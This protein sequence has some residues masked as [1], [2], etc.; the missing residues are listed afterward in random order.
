MT[1]NIGSDIIVKAKS[2][3]SKIKEEV[4]VILHRTFRPE[5]LNRIDAIC[6]FRKLDEK[7][8]VEV[9]KIH[10][11]QLEGRLQDQDITVSITND[12][13]KKIA[14]LGY[15]PEFG[16]RPL[17]RAIQAHITVPI[18]QYLLKHPTTKTITVKVEKG[19]ILVN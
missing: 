13:I 8:I 1:S 6:F 10:L 19:K 2:L 9:A 4:E 14:A 17:K 12:V 3:T 15:S 5:F 16:A 7:D 11:K 18:S